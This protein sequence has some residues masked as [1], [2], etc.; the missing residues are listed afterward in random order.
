MSVLSH[1]RVTATSSVLTE[2]AITFAV[3]TSFVEIINGATNTFW[4]TFDGTGV[5]SVSLGILF[6]ANATRT[7]PVEDAKNIKFIRATGTDADFEVICHG[8]RGV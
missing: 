3:G 5:P 6:S 8:G 7:V 2:S 1:E 4:A